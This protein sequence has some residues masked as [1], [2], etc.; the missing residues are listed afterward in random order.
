MRGGLNTYAYVDSN[1]LYW[2]DP[3]GLDNMN[4]FIGGWTGGTTDEL[5]Y[6]PP[7]DVAWQLSYQQFQ[8]SKECASCRTR[9][10]GEF[11]NPVPGIG[12]EYGAGEVGDK[13]GPVAKELA[14]DTAKKFN[15][16]YGAYD[17]SSCLDGCSE[18]CKYE[19]CMENAYNTGDACFTGCSD[20]LYNK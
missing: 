13:L 14:K 6:P 1:P 11:V 5:P 9:C 18:I 10:V 8:S 16:F 12:I 7:Q 17:L 2:I 20:I 15:K 4:G 19:N 3:F